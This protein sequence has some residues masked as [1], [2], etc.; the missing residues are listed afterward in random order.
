MYELMKRDWRVLRNHDPEKSELSTYLNIFVERRLL[1]MRE[2]LENEAEAIDQ[3]P[4]VSEE[5]DEPEI[6]NNITDFESKVKVGRCIDTSISRWNKAATLAQDEDEVHAAQRSI[7]AAQFIRM[8][9]LGQYL[10]LTCGRI[11][12]SH[13]RY[14][15]VQEENENGVS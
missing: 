1:D 6:P 11:R 15:Q 2:K 4:E 12:F 5:P 10:P 9:L 13:D 14:I 7:A 8:Q 3:Q